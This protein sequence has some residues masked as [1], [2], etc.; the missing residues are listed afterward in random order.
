LVIGGFT[1]LAGMLLYIPGRWW[2]KR[3]LRNAPDESIG[4]A[5]VTRAGYLFFAIMIGLLLIGFAQEHI[6][7]SS[8]LGEFVSTRAGRLVFLGSFA[9]AGFVIE[10]LLAR[11][12]IKLVRRETD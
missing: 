2:A 11:A 8:R 6:A 5:R 7:P 12:G 4:K 9:A 3:Q 1:V 10:N